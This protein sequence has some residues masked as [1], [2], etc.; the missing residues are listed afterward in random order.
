MAGE[1]GL[2]PRRLL[3]L[4]LVFK[5]STLPIRFI[6]PCV[7]EGTVADTDRVTPTQCLVGTPQ[8]VWIYSPLVGK[9]RF[10]LARFSTLVSKTN[11]ATI[12]SLAQ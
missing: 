5:T 6:L 9:A 4:L 8:T 12:T 2:E 10:E 1:L 11:M 7:A 3:R